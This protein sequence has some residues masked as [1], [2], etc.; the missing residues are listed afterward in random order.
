MVQYC[1]IYFLTL[2]PIYSPYTRPSETIIIN[3]ASIKRQINRL[4]SDILTW[5]IQIYDYIHTCMSKVNT[6]IIDQ[7]RVVLFFWR[8][9]MYVC[10]QPITGYDDWGCPVSKGGRPLSADTIRTG[11]EANYVISAFCPRTSVGIIVHWLHECPRKQ[12]GRDK[13]RLRTGSG[14]CG[15]VADRLRIYKIGFRVLSASCPRPS[16]RA[17]SLTSYELSCN[18]ASDNSDCADW[19]G[20]PGQSHTPCAHAIII[21]M[22]SNH[23]WRISWRNRY[24]KSCKK[25]FAFL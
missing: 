25:M 17:V 3:Q 24:A 22:L 20:Y 13:D 9:Y 21:I 16:G 4:S 15:Q 6:C 19:P 8:V 23:E 7:S 12:S 1:N 2:L 10:A 11:S 14:I 5:L 18:M